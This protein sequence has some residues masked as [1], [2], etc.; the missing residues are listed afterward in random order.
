ME[1]KQAC[2][3]QHNQCHSVKGVP[4][5]RNPRPRLEGRGLGGSRAGLSALPEGRTF[6]RAG[7]G[8]GGIG[9]GRADTCGAGCVGRGGRGTRTG[10]HERD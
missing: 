1:K 6:R 4:P 8:V 10:G 3:K 2:I 5:H 9:G 7:T